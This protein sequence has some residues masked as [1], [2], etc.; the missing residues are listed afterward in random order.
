MYTRLPVYV[1]ER[2]ESPRPCTNLDSDSISTTLETQSGL[3]TSQLKPLG[4]HVH[5]QSIIATKLMTQ[6]PHLT[7]LLTLI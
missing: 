1:T 2:A 4:R 3:T 5:A 7:L 6:D